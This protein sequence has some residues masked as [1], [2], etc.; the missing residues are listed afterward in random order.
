MADKDEKG[1]QVSVTWGD[2]PDIVMS[3]R[4]NIILMEPVVHAGCVHG[5]CGH[6]Q[7]DLTREE[8]RSLASDLIRAA[9][10][11]EELEEMLESTEKLGGSSF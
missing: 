9:H 1:V 3:I 7:V 6:G 8:A 5:S 11:A 10:H 4:Q 2:G